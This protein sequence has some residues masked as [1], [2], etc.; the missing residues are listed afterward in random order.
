MLNKNKKR[1]LS[2]GYGYVN[3]FTS[4]C[5]CH[6]IHHLTYIVSLRCA[7]RTK[8]SGYSCVAY[9][10]ELCACAILISS[11]NYFN[12]RQNRQTGK[13]TNTQTKR[14][15]CQSFCVADTFLFFRLGQL[16]TKLTN[17]RCMVFMWAESPYFVQI[18]RAHL[19]FP[20]VYCPDF[21]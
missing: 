16:A 3:V 5:R 19:L 21:L 1:I 9:V 17:I 2:Y 12:A 20:F 15:N 18:S 13:H 11:R 8:H 10:F 6:N 4:M 7:P 14:K